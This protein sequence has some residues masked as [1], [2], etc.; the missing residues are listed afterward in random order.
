MRLCNNCIWVCAELSSRLGQEMAPMAPGLIE[1]IMSLLL[2][3]YGKQ[4]PGYLADNCVLALGRLGHVAP[5]PL[6]KE[7]PRLADVWCRRMC[8]VHEGE[9]KKHAFAGFLRLVQHNPHAL[10]PHLPVLVTSVINYRTVEP[11]TEEPFKQLLA[12]YQSMLGP[13]RWEQA[14]APMVPDARQA[15]RQRFSV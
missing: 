3:A 12:A 15:V 7:L 8:A 14:L 11:D 13:E 2:G 6:A 4:P 9:E 10:V 5:E 1:R